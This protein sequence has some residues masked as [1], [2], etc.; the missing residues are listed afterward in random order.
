M[1]RLLVAFVAVL[2]VLGFSM[3]GLAQGE[4]AATGSQ[5]TTMMPE[6]KME[7]MEKV[8]SF[9]GKVIAV[10]KTAKTITVKGKEGE[11]VFDVS[12]ATTGEILPGEKVNVK[13]TKEGE[14]AILAASSV[15]M[16]EP[17][18]SNNAKQGITNELGVKKEGM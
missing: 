5:Q 2:M 8:A 1:K 3:V 12:K 16:V 15:T 10:D 9:S 6:K 14:K 11:K 4:K 13:Y 7:S 18:L 17:K